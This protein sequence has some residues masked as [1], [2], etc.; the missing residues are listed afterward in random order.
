MASSSS[1]GFSNTKFS[2]A[3]MVSAA[4][5]SALSKCCATDFLL[6]M[7][8]VEKRRFAGLALF[9]NVCRRNKINLYSDCCEQCLR[10]EPL[11]DEFSKHLYSLRCIVIL[12]V[13]QD[14]RYDL[15]TKDF[16]VHT[17]DY[18]GT[19]LLLLR[20]TWFFG[21]YDTS[22]TVY[23]TI[24]HS[25]KEISSWQHGKPYKIQSSSL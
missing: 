2:L 19:S 14:C 1:V 21:M 10:G 22:T 16:L 17:E 13:R 9:K 4:R 18:M 3:T 12:G 20:N 24:I 11:E 25:K 5:T 6:P 15:S 7:L 8:T 23:F